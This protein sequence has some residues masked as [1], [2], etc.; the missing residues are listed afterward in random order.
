MTGHPR[1]AS[2]R[3][4]RIP[5]FSIVVE[6]ENLALEGSD[7][8]VRCLDSLRHQSVD[9]A[10]ANE[11][12]VTNSG[13]VPPELAFR[14][15]S[16]LELLEFRQLPEDT[17]YFEAKMLG[18]AEATGD[19][20]VF[21][22]SDVEYEPDWLRAMLTSITGDEDVQIV[23]GET[24]YE[25]TGPYSLAMALAFQFPPFS[26]RRRIWKSRG[27]AANS[28]ALRRDLLKSHP[29][30]TEAGLR[31]GNCRMHANRLIRAG[32]PIWRQPAARA[33]H[34]LLSPSRFFRRFFLGGHHAWVVHL[35]DSD[36]SA[37]TSPASRLAGHLVAAAGICARPVILPFHRLPAALRG[38]PVRLVMLPLAAPVVLAAILTYLSGFFLTV[39][40]PDTDFSA[41]TDRS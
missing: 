23:G 30:P 6:T 25:I 37:G 14:L 15:K 10:E 7:A 4:S 5:S 12:I 2:R 34:R 19:V 33:A 22:D 36:R 38:H 29:F 3:P 35:S 13:D 8:I 41:L 1:G 17:G 39:L 24:A 40:R 16:D 9:I 31:H 20:L 18:A 28:I 11:V 27:Y 32:I 26:G 21:C